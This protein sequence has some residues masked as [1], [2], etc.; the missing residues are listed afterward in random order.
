MASRNH[1][2]VTQFFFVALSNILGLPF[3]SLFFLV[4]VFY[5]F[6]LVGNIVI[7]MITVV[8]RALR[9]PMYF[10]LQNLSFLEIGYTSSTIP[11]ML[12]NFLS[13]NTSISFLGCATQM[14]FFSFLGITECCLLAAMAYDRY[15]AI[16][17]LLHYTAMISRGVCLQLSAVCWLIG[18][19]VGVG[20]TIFLFTLP[21]CGPNRINHFFYNLPLL[22][23]LACADTYRNEV[24]VY[25]IAVTFIAVT[26]ITTFLLILVSYVH[27]LHAILSIPSAAGRS[28]A[29]STRFSHL[30]VVTLFFGSSIVT[31]LRPKS[32]YSLN[33]DKLLS[34]FYSVVSPM[35][36]PLIYS[37]PAQLVKRRGPYYSKEN[38]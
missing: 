24:A 14:Y 7:I 18:V 1:R 25:T 5:L 2:A 22:L 6:T 32:R 12:V 34:L 38:S 11:K 15:V 19:L 27:I 35:L 4:L 17:H 23:K 31:Y 36:N 20:Q 26:F 30:T 28:K 29:F 9:S 13:E 37:R 21:Y 10:F 33:T 3:F 8:D 16:C